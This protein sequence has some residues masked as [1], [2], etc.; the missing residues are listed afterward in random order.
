MTFL[1]HNTASG[2][3]EEF[4]PLEPGHVRLYTCGPTVWN[5]A[6]IGN[7]RTFLFYDLLRRHLRF[8]GY[9]LTHVVNIT[10]IED[11][12]IS[13][14]TERGVSIREY[15]GPYEEAFLEDL[16]TI[17]FQGVEVMPRATEHVPEMVAMVEKLLAKGN[18]YQADADVYY[19]VSSFPRYG[20][21]AHLDRAGLKAGARVA[22]DD[23]DKE[24][25]V[26]FALWKGEQPGEAAVGAVWEA[27][28]GRGRPGWHIEC[29][30]MSL[31]Y[32]G[33]TFD[34]HA[35][36]IDLLFP[37]HQNEVA[38][39]EAANEAPLAR[40]WL[41]SEHL[42]DAT[43][44]KM[45]KRLGNVATLRDLLDAGHD[46]VA[47]RFFLLAS[48]HYRQKLRLDETG[49]RAAAEQVRRLRDFAARVDR[50]QPAPADDPF[51]VQELE[52][53]RHHYR[54]ALDDDL[55]LPQAVG[56]LFDA[57]REANAG[58]DQGRAGPAAL[59][60]MRVLLDDADQH[61]D[62]LKEEDRSLEAE[63]ERLIAE[64]EAARA[65]RDFA[66]AD[67]IREEL[68]ARGISLEDTKEGVRWRP[69]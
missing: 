42:A 27:P 61:L 7:F 6:H 19:R 51:L 26:D 50:S 48:A 45:S 43:G 14:A 34:I 58:L 11:R 21:L 36:G 68:K 20:E 32:L 16:A 31:K 2:G 57:V 22:A 29:S 23:Y 47:I 46:P 9:R 5:F 60:A 44:A 37:H 53:A 69:A 28:F 63:V 10:D 49:I 64:R 18:A 15:A 65:A 41:H 33:P 52:D 13:H 1:L 59:A 4:E 17:R 25:V 62:V 39:S 40:V 3:K 24:D 38:Q 30:A 55:N 67:A 35:G 8:S 12:I 56:Y 66:R 54:A